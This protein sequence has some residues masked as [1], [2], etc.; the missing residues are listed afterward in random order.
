MT[1][2]PSI[3]QNPPPLLWR[4]HKKKKGE[5]DMSTEKKLHI[6]TLALHVGQE[7]AD[8]FALMKL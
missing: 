5:L 8:A 6:E 4:L 2:V 1:L 3:Q 7:Q